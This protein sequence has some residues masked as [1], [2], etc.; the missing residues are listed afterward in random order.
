MGQLILE[1]R[2]AIRGVETLTVAGLDLGQKQDYTALAILERHKI[3]YT[4]RNALTWEYLTATEHVLTHIERLPLHLP[5][6]ELIQLVRDRL[7]MI[8]PQN[9]GPLQLIVDATGA[10]IPV[11]DLIRAS[12]LSRGLVPVTITSGQSVTQGQDGYGVPKRTLISGLQ[13]AFENHDLHLAAGLGESV[14]V[15]IGELMEMRCKVS[16]SGHE[17]FGVWRDGLHDDLVL[18][19]ALAWWG[20]SRQ[21]ATPPVWGTR[22]LI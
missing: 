12:G 8:P 9:G 10:G 15:L 16:E 3:T 2:G 17:K 1:D 13:V 6:P 20:M 4:A 21:K 7:Q 14:E 5:Y 19:T 22:R 18:A 11:V